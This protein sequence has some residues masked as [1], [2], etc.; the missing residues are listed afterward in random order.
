[1]EIVRERE[2]LTAK[3]V[4][5]SQTFSENNHFIFSMTHKIWP[6][7]F[8]PSNIHSKVLLN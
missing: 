2:N 5:N 3:I 6:E 4:L 8:L 1:M 7:A